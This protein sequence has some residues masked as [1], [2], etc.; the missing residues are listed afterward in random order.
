MSL[1][2]F[3]RHLLRSSWSRAS[4]QFGLL[5]WKASVSLP[6][7]VP[8]PCYYTLVPLPLLISRTTVNKSNCRIVHYIIMSSTTF[9]GTST[10][11]IYKQTS[12]TVS[13]LQYSVWMLH[14][15][16][17][18]QILFNLPDIYSDSRG[19]VRSRLGLRDN[20]YRDFNFKSRFEDVLESPGETP[21]NCRW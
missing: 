8:W 20:N 12:D 4:T 13:V 11:S 1:Q 3:N 19:D 14:V 17:I 7:C 15:L 5:Q 9:S 21:L 16:I 6:Y 10:I 18:S 2:G